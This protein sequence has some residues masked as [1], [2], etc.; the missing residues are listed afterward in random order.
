M[1]HDLCEQI[2]RNSIYD[3]GTRQTFVSSDSRT[4]I[5]CDDSVAMGLRVITHSKELGSCCRSFLCLVASD[6]E[7]G[8]EAGLLLF[9][10][11]PF[12]DI[13]DGARHA[14]RFAI[15]VPERLSTHSKPIVPAISGLEERL[16]IERR[17]VCAVRRQVGFHC[18]HHRICAVP[19][20]N[21]KL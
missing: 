1:A 14:D 17:R 2:I 20:F 10:V 3:D 18:C 6:G 4:N 7:V 21:A 5:V 8:N 15:F 12:R 16:H 9:P 13:R 19:I 11:P